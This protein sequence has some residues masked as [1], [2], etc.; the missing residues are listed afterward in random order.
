MGTAKGKTLAYTVA[1]IYEIV[2]K[3]RA[4]VPAEA[5]FAASGGWLW[6]PPD[7]PAPKASMPI[8]PVILSGGSGTRLWPLSRPERPKQLLPLAAERTMLEMTAARVA[9]RGRFGAPLV[10]A[11]AAHETEV[12]AQLGAAGAGDARMILEPAGRNTA[13]AIALAALAADSDTLLL[14]LPSDHLIADEA[15]FQAAIDAAAPA[16]AEGRLVCFGLRP[17]TPETGYG[18]IEGGAEVGPGVHDALRFVEKPDAETAQ[19]YLDSG[20]FLWNGGIFLFRAGAMLDA[21]GRYVPLV[22][23]AARRAWNGGRWDGSNFH[24]HAGSWSAAPSIAIDVAVMERSDKVAVVP[25]SMGWSDVGSWDA[26]YEVADKDGA[27]N[28]LRGEVDAIDAS[29]LLVRA[30]GI[31]ISCVGVQDLIVVATGDHV[32]VMP[33]GSSQRVREAVDALKARKEH[34]D[35]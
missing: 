14:V 7:L 3:R 2:V 22:L 13:P 6:V 15:A 34:P 27:R 10:I 29:G 18:Y 24:P 16:A 23:D 8:T 30:Q 25:V 19:A 11:G 32:L 31:H 12:A 26:L 5:A 17:T 35:A 28:S 21:L 4:S 20:R 9:D 33:R 1:P